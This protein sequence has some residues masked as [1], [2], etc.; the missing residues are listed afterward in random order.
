LYFGHYLNI[1][2]ERVKDGRCCLNPET[3]KTTIYWGF[4][5]LWESAGQPD[6]TS[7]T[8]L[9]NGVLL[10]GAPHKENRIIGNCPRPY[11]LRNN[12]FISF[13]L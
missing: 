10:V 1:E 8:S 4:L 3:E 11:I 9:I 5:C 7:K 12:N 13:G 6:A 2:E